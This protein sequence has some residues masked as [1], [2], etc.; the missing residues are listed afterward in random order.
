MHVE[1]TQVAKYLFLDGICV[2][3]TLLTCNLERKIDKSTDNFG[4]YI[5]TKYTNHIL[6]RKKVKTIKDIDFPC[7]IC[8]KVIKDE[9]YIINF[10]G[11]KCQGSRFVG[12][13]FRYIFHTYKVTIF[14]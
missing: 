5:N 4:K 8:Q 7:Q 12:F 10:V 13:T 9:R 14:K 6:E 1:P 3:F 11:G 2:I